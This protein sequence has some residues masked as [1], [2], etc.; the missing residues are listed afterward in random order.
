M[1]FARTLRHIAVIAALLIVGQSPAR[2]QAPAPGSLI[3]PAEETPI[4]LARA[5]VRIEVLRAKSAADGPSP[6]AQVRSTFIL[7]NPGTAAVSQTV[8]LLLA[9]SERGPELEGA[10][11]TLR[12]RPLPLLIDSVPR[13]DSGLARVASAALLLPASSEVP[14]VTEYFAQSAAQPPYGR[15]RYLLSTGGGWAGPIESVEF[16]LSLPYPANAENVLLEHSSP[17]GRFLG[18]QV[19]W[20]FEALEPAADQVFFVTVLSP[21]TWERILAARRAVQLRPRSAQA[22]RA[23]AR[24]YLSA[25]YVAEDGPQLGVGFIPLMED[26]YRRA[27]ARAPAS[28]RLHAEFAQAL[29]SLY[30]RDLPAEVFEKILAALRVALA[31]DPRDALTQQVIAALRERL[32]KRAQGTGP[33]AET[34]RQQLAQLEQL[35]SIGATP[36]PAPTT[37]PMPET[38]TVTLAPTVTLTPEPEAPTITPAPTMPDVGEATPTALPTPTPNAETATPTAELPAATDATPLPTEPPPADEATPTAAPDAALAVTDVPVPTAVVTLPVARAPT[39]APAGPLVS[40]PV[41]LLLLA[42]AY[43]L[44]GLTVYL[45]HSVRARRDRAQAEAPILASSKDEDKD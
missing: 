27:Q 5:Q 7:R 24:A 34:A 42:L 39:D 35:L 12:R 18:G 33:E 28:A 21:A 17:G 26:A 45:I 31:R 22:W 3:Q 41:G 38:L 11:M 6:V 19:R 30:P 8:Q 23:L 25:I 16:I 20:R 14:L 9:E 1:S 43:V 29:L 37:T 40:L 32:A 2:A 4:Q 36:T 15:F 44:G 13:P 10:V